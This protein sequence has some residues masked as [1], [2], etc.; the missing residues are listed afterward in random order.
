[1][2]GFD[3]S[4]ILGIGFKRYGS[5]EK[6]VEDPIHH[7]YDVYVAINKDITAEK[8]AAAKKAEDTGV[9]SVGFLLFF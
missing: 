3:I 8:E 6:L 1:M 5:E 4:G 9:P 7:L 2:G